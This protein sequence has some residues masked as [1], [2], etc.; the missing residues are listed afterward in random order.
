MVL[1][2]ANIHFEALLTKYHQKE[3]LESDPIQ[4]AHRY[5][6]SRDQETVAFISALFAYGS[7]TLI[8]RAIATI[9]EPMGTHPHAFIK[10]YNQDIDHWPKFSHRFHK[11][12]HLRVLFLTLNRLFKMH[13]SL[14][15]FFKSTYLK[16]TDFEDFLNQIAEIFWKEFESVIAEFGFK[17]NE[18][19]RGMR[20]FINAPKGGSACKR[21]VMFL[22]WMSRKDSIDFGL[23]NAWLHPSKLIVPLDT[24]VSRISYYLKLRK[25][26]E[27][28]NANWKMALEVTRSLAKICA[29][30]PVKYDF[31]LARLGILDVCQ[32]KWVKSVCVQCP[33]IQICRYPNLAK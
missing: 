28:R 22:R 2:N 8:H 16:S 27:S 23:W 21:M 19:W 24:H 33:L 9:L 13:G 10:K 7:V 30:D 17:K 1:S 3:W 14:E 29:D 32:K 18:V 26:T 4:F 15:G 5:T 25:G 11:S 6:N 12:A 20:F 31:A